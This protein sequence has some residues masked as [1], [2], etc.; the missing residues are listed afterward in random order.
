[1]SRVPRACTVPTF[2]ALAV[3]LAA[4]AAPGPQKQ[5]AP[6]KPLQGVPKAETAWS[7]ESMMK[8]KKVGGVQVSPDGK[9]V[10]Y[11]VTEAVMDGDRSEFVAQ[12]FLA[13]ADGKNPRQLTF[14][15]KSSDNPQWS[16]DGQALAF[17]STRTG[18]RNLWLLRLAGGEAEQLTDVKTGVS[19]FK[20]APDGKSIAFTMADAPTAAQEKQAKQKDDARVIDENTRHVRLHVLP[21]AKDDKGQRKTRVLTKGKFSVGFILSPAAYDWS[22]DS[23]TIAFT[24]TPTPSP[25]DWVKADISLVDVASG[26][27][28]AFAKTAAAEAMPL[29]SPDGKRIAYVASDDP[30]TWGFKLR[31]LVQPVAGGPARKLEETF[32]Q[33][34][35]LVGWARDASRIYYTENVST[36]PTLCAV[37]V[38]PEGQDGNYEEYGPRPGG[39]IGDVS[40]NHTGTHFGFTLQGMNRPAEAFVNATTKDFEPVQISR[41]NEALL[42]GKPII[43][44][45]VVTWKPGGGASNVQGLLTFP[46]GYEKDKKYPLL[47]VIH[48]GPAGVYSQTFLGNLYPYPVAA[49]AAKGYL[50]LR[51]NPRGSSGRGAAFRY[52]NYKDWGQGDYQDLMAGVDHVIKMGVADPERMGVMGWSYGGYMTSWVITQTKRFRAASI[53]APVTDLVSFSG[54]ADIPGFLPDYFGGEPWQQP[55]LFRKHSPITHVK[56]VMTPALILHGEKDDRVPIG[57]GYQYYS[58]LKRQGVTTRM[59]VYPRMPHGPTEPRHYLDIMKRNVAWMDEHVRGDKK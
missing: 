38:P 14:A 4:T 17:A 19:S 57:Q 56:G 7:P 9:R 48:G 10:V 40:L 8:V 34:P 25:D 6:Q 54:T 39:A 46:I 43:R 33:R 26:K 30:P 13:D 5:E 53:G 36:V 49:F 20:W 15:D 51:C 58:A 44:T 16:P 11:V 41:G 31:V 42:K 47:L 37:T 3:A 35:N 29:F 50:V 24:H 1:M 18:K 32:D 2:A 52:A 59:V 23:K 27:V 21:V 12:I 28:T 45:I 55:E 22:P